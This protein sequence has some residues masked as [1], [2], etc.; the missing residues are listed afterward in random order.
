[1]GEEGMS[2]IYIVEWVDSKLLTGGWESAEHTKGKEVCK[3][4]SVGILQAKT[5]EQITLQP[6]VS[7]GDYCQ[8]VVIPRC[9]IKRMRRLK[10]A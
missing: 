9:S 6:N 3:V 2:K 7:D 1:M 10:I 4:T 5:D 8:G